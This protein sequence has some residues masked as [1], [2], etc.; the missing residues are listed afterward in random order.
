MEFKKNQW[1]KESL[2]QALVRDFPGC[3]TALEALK[4]AIE[5]KNPE[6]KKEPIVEAPKPSLDEW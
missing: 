3:K 4:K 2:R 6:I 5:K 1:P